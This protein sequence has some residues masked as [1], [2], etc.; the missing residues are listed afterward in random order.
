MHA[1]KCGGLAVIQKENA[2]EFRRTRLGAVACNMA[3]GGATS[4]NCG[5]G[6]SVK[7]FN[8]EIQGDKRNV[9]KA[10]L[11]KKGFTVKLAGG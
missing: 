4:K 5:V 8:I 1:R 11:E 9:L 3:V 7:D 6:G 2:G 10:E